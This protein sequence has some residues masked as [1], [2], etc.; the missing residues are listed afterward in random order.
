MDND[1]EIEPKEAEQQ[2]VMAAEEGDDWRRPFVECFQHGTL[3]KD[4]RA[5]DQLRLRVLRYA[6]V[7]NTMYRRSYDQL[8]LI[9]M[10]RRIYVSFFRS[11]APE[12]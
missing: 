8:W 9:H 2:E 12:R 11:P 1:E 6:Y 3:P 4:K 10:F 7:G 5:A